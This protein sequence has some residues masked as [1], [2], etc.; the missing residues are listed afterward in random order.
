MQRLIDNGSES[1]Q[2]ERAIQPHMGTKIEAKQLLRASLQSEKTRH[3]E[4]GNV[5]DMST[6]DSCVSQDGR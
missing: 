1:I 2:S 6:D 3:L 5:V 4:E